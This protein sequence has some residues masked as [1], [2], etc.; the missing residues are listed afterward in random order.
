MDIPQHQFE[1]ILKHELH[2]YA[3]SLLPDLKVIL[4][5]QGGD[6]FAGGYSA[7]RPASWRTWAQFCSVL[8]DK[9]T[10]FRVGS[11]G[12]PPEWYKLFADGF[13]KLPDDDY[14]LFG[15]EQL[16]ST[17]SLQIYNLW[18]EDRTSSVQG[19]EARV[20]FLDYRLVELLC[21]VPQSLHQELFWNKTIVRRAAE[22]WLPKEMAQRRKVPLY[23]EDSQII[24]QVNYSILKAVFPDFCSEYLADGTCPFSETALREVLRRSGPEGDRSNWMN[25]L[26]HVMAIS[27]FHRMCSRRCEDFPGR[28]LDTP[29]PLH[30]AK[31]VGSA[32]WAPAD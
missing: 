30:E 6:E 29:S 26:L 31:E 3:K 1:W 13:A 5:G 15:F 23:S 25:L 2:R 27:V 20:P 7:M 10:Y 17:Q 11:L 32:L 21:S 12:L 22:Q 14:S 8:Q 16:C 28:C 19:V 4:L 24:D 18:H 9:R